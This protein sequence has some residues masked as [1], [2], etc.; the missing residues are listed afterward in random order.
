MRIRTIFYLVLLLFIPVS[1]HAQGDVSYIGEYCFDLVS[2]FPDRP[3]KNLQIGI[4]SFG[5]GHF[6]LH[7]KAVVQG[8]I[9][10]VHGTAVLDGDSV[11]MTLNAA[12]PTPGSI[13]TTIYIHFTVSTSLGTYDEIYQLV[14]ILGEPRQW[15]VETS[16][17][18]G[19]VTL[20]A[21]Q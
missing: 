3:I 7:G 1:S 6:P 10:P 16:I 17:D 15:Q 2:V 20:H 5:A 18:S 11:S 12:G 13:K 21:C 19:S 9:L 14:P 8:A 4:L